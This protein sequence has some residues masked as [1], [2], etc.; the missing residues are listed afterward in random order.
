MDTIA[1]FLFFVLISSPAL[2]FVGLLI[3][4]VRE[5][6]ERW[7]PP[8]I[9]RPLMCGTWKWD[10]TC[11]RLV[12]REKLMASAG[13]NT[14]KAINTFKLPTTMKLTTYQQAVEH[15]R[16]GYYS[17]VKDD[18]GNCAVLTTKNNNGSGF[19][20]TAWAS[21]D[22]TTS[23]RDLG[24]ATSE[25]DYIDNLTMVRPIHPSCFMGGGL[26]VG[27]KVRIKYPIF[28]NYDKV[29]EITGIA[30]DAEAKLTSGDVKYQLDNGG[31]E[32][33]QAALIPAPFE[34]QDSQAV[35]DAIELLKRE[36]K[37]VDGKILNA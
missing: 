11:W 27:D 37:L 22:A 12:I 5:K 17:L 7:P 29:Y 13:E 23:S 34:K 16:M 36:G 18:F 24:V 4:T 2:V 32:F 20:R 25:R 14:T 19:Y 3:W 8:P 6:D 28:E 30:T 21:E 1:N 26:K 33:S 15:Y 35:L 31:R 9:P 10:G